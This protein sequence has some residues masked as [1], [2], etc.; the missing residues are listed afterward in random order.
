MNS[1]P[2]ILLF[3]DK[4]GYPVNPDNPAKQTKR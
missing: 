4:Q 3:Y 2:A 1:S